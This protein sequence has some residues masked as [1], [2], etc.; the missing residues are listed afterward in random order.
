MEK[1][2]ERQRAKLRKRR[3]EPAEISLSFLLRMFICLVV[4]LAFAGVKM[5]G[6]ETFLQM[7]KQVA[8]YLNGA[9]GIAQAYDES[10]E[11]INR[12]CDRIIEAQNAND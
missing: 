12:L 6:G 9:S 11:A 1:R 2:Y 4:F 10:V 3:E 8:C 5:R 7:Q